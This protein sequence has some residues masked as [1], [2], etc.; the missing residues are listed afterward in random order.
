MY[1]GITE[2]AITGISD[3][4]TSIT[5]VGQQLTV[6]NT[7]NNIVG[8]CFNAPEDATITKIGVNFYSSTG[9]AA[10]SLKLVITG[11]T[12]TGFGDTGNI[13][14]QTN[15]YLYNDAAIT[16]ST[17][18]TYTYLDITR[19]GS[20]NTISSYNITKGSWYFIG[21]MRANATGWSSTEYISVGLTA[22]SS[23]GDYFFWTS[24]SPYHQA[25]TTAKQLSG[26]ALVL[27]STTAY[28]KGFGGH[29]SQTIATGTN[30]NYGLRFNLPNDFGDSVT[31][32]GINFACY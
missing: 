10:K 2:I 4:G 12:A 32:C 11:L 25:S 30:T 22:N 3:V 6:G 9:T 26:N 16:Y 5:T 14:A 17:T 28:G 24:G 8:V 20:G 31:L 21:I 15:D 19:D 27:S 23:G 18:G 13:L 1:N 7:A 29:G